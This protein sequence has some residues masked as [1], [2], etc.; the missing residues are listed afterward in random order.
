MALCCSFKT[1]ARPNTL[2][3]LPRVPCFGGN[4]VPS[5]PELL[6]VDDATV[7]G[8]AAVLVALSRQNKATGT[9]LPLRGY[10]GNQE[11]KADRELL[12]S[13]LPGL[14]GRTLLLATI[15]TYMTNLF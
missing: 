15:S 6:M 4:A 8:A 2:H 7:P 11:E 5:I 10:R 14:G 3:R 1:K 12:Q 9:A 13:P